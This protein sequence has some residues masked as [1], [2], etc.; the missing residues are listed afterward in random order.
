MVDRGEPVDDEE[1]IIGP[2]GFVAERL[3]GYRE[4]RVDEFIVRDHAATPLPEALESLSALADLA[5]PLQ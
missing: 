3:T 2:A 5:P 1:D 4:A